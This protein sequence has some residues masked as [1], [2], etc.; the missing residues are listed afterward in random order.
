MWPLYELKLEGNERQ[1]T[2]IL[3]NLCIC[4]LN[5]MY[6]NNIE[7]ISVMNSRQYIFVFTLFLTI[8]QKSNIPKKGEITYQ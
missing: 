1:C 3:L 7:N 2:F 5:E 6:Y 4:F 8:E